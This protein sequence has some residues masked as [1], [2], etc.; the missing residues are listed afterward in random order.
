MHPIE[1]GGDYRMNIREYQ[2]GSRSGAISNRTNSLLCIS[3]M[4]LML[5]ASPPES[6]CRAS[7][8]AVQSR[9]NVGPL[10][11]LEAQYRPY[12][13]AQPGPYTNLSIIH[14]QLENGEATQ[15]GILL[16][17][18][19]CLIIQRVGPAQGLACDIDSGWD[20]LPPER[21]VLFLSDDQFTRYRGSNAPFGGLWV[22]NQMPNPRKIGFGTL[23]INFLAVVP[24]LIPSPNVVSNRIAIIITNLSNG[25]ELTLK[26][27][28]STGLINESTT[29]RGGTATERIQ[30]DALTPIDSARFSIESNDLVNLHR[31]YGIAPEYP[32]NSA[33]FSGV[34]MVIRQ[35]SGDCPIVISRVIP[36]FDA[37]N[38]GIL[39]G[40]CLLKINGREVSNLK[41]MDVVT[42]LRG[43]EGESIYI[44]IR[45]NTTERTLSLR[46]SQGSDGFKSRLPET[47]R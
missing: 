42:A 45:R 6:I 22:K 24:E 40:D 16:Q 36:G 20:N 4:A 17:G 8:P 27:D 5:S 33:P 23:G 15:A 1:P 19:K 37:A 10:P 11:L 44:T 3:A 25:L 31:F 47:T 39:P 9:H 32:T 34:G 2:V 30:V 18:D 21:D 43:P 12:T 46:I 29:R 13:L 28:I 38:Q 7:E 14:R 41:L 35:G 26:Y